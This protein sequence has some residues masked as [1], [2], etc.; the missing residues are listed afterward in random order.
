MMTDPVAGGPIHPTSV[1]G[2]LGRALLAW[3]VTFAPA[4]A[5]P[6]V[7]AAPTEVRQ[8]NLSLGERIYREGVLPS[9]KPVRAM[10]EGDIPV[11]GRM[12]TCASCHLMSG[13]G[14]DEG[15]VVT[16]PV[17]ASYLFKP[18]ARGVRSPFQFMPNASAR[19]TPPP[20]FDSGFLR[21][22]YT[23]ETLARAIRTGINPVG[24]ELD[25]IMPRFDLDDG[26]M[27]ELISYLEQLS[28]RYSPGV[29]STTLKFATVISDG[30]PPENRDAMLTVLRAYIETKNAQPRHQRR[31]A[32][33]GPF[34]R[35]EVETS[36][37]DLEL[38]VWK[39]T[40]PPDSWSA[41]L[42]RYNS[43]QPVFALLGGMVAGDWHPVHKFCE[44]NKLPALFPLTDDPAVSEHNWYT[45]YFS[46]GVVQEAEAAARY[47]RTLRGVGPQAKITQ[48]YR[49]DERGAQA[50]RSFEE[51]WKALGG[52][53]T[54]VKVLAAHEKLTAAVI[55]ELLASQ[56]PAP[57]LLWLGRQDIASLSGLSSASHQPQLLMVSYGLLEKDLAIIPD[58]IR[59]I[60]LITYPNA[61]SADK[62]R[63]L[64]AVRS[65]L[66]TR[67]ITTDD[68]EIPAK[69]YFL[70]WM[71]SGVLMEMRNDFYS[72]YFLDTMDMMPDQ[73]YA[74]AVYPR[75][76]FGPG[77]R[78]ASKGCYIVR[79]TR[80]KNPRIVKESDWVVQ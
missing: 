53:P 61:L 40:G 72:D 78:Y 49:R 71:L 46:K 34:Y 22:A 76:S 39:L 65:W 17:S 60:T 31:R 27:A 2:V 4:Y 47:L 7:Q 28:P 23:A 79:L 63:P 66:E 51:T 50:A 64:L 54:S 59:D 32:A 58:E 45:L 21:P 62:E 18:L 20:D 11:D 48:I 12:L 57:V 67:E 16:P 35:R 24:R 26:A 77:Q 19:E 42:R 41:Q 13:L 43:E 14:S 68:I 44:D 38:V 70:G 37:R 6:G 56:G 55:E 15:S 52:N 8:A 33:A 1:G 74:V 3:M 75:L 10:V 73:D 9:G 25:D 69:M 36:Y 80:G 29:S 5:T 30:V